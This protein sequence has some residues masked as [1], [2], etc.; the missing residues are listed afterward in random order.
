MNNGKKLKAYCEMTSWSY[1][2]GQQI[3]DEEIAR[4]A[5]IRIKDGVGKF[6]TEGLQMNKY[7][8][9]IT[10]LT[11]S[12]LS[13]FSAF[14]KS[15][16]EA[17]DNKVQSSVKISGTSGDV[18][19]TFSGKLLSFSLPK[20]IQKK[21]KDDKGAVEYGQK[22][23]NEIFLKAAPYVPD[24]IYEKSKLSYEERQE[25]IN[26]PEKQKV[27]QTLQTKFGSTIGRNTV[28]YMPL[29][30]HILDICDEMLIYGRP[31]ATI[32]KETLSIREAV[33]LCG[34]VQLGKWMDVVKAKN[35][36]Y[37]T[38]VP[39]GYDE[40]E[41]QKQ[42]KY[43]TGFIDV[44]SSRAYSKAVG[45]IPEKPINEDCPCFSVDDF[46]HLSPQ[47]KKELL[48]MFKY[49][50]NN[51]KDAS[52]L[53]PSQ[54]VNHYLELQAD[55]TGYTYVS[56]H[57]KKKLKKEKA[58]RLQKLCLELLTYSRPLL[59]LNIKD[60]SLERTIY[61]CH[62]HYAM[63]FY[64]KQKAGDDR[65]KELQ[66]KEKIIY[67]RE[68]NAMITLGER[69]RRPE[70]IQFGEDM[71]QAEKNTTRFRQDETRTL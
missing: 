25:F 24:I 58:I 32:R 19:L 1:L 12:M 64:R 52:V 47:Q 59:L 71:L 14:G 20:V 3:T 45:L 39:D 27:M 31:L 48:E 15:E 68:A 11:V 62:F 4:T 35:R 57:A 18:N 49:L 28:W 26:S 44:Y 56:R 2:T 22:R 29:M 65:Q 41:A 37:K 16:S 54:M 43:L 67:E 10:I 42:R 23:R 63:D 55:K 51:I 5:A 6:F 40:R 17:D 60:Y 61:I 38:I 50:P 70:W 7:I 69:F 8:L 13:A 36:E 9:E 53:A 21:S 33:D 34:M 30:K 46:S 66:E